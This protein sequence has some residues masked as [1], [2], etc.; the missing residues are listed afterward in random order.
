MR[1]ILFLSGYVLLFLVLIATSA[2][3]GLRCGTKLVNVGDTKLEVLAKC[4]EPD[5]KEIIK[6][7]GV[8]VEKWHYDCGTREFIRI[9]TFALGEL[10]VIET[11]DYGNAPNR[12][13]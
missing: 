2:V 10:Q 11:G 13:R 7:N 9:F 12:C 5:L 6:K 3:S 8:I 4:G 1:K